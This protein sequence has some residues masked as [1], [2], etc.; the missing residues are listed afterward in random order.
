MIEFDEAAARTIEA[1]YQTPDVVEQRRAVSAALDLRPGERVLD[2]GCGPGLL[3]Q[4]MAEAVE[5]GG[6][7]HGIDPSPSMVEM[8]RRR[9]AAV[10]GARVEV[11]PGE[12][13]E[14]PFPD[15]HFDAVVA[16]QVYEY[17]AAMP[18][19]LTEARRVLVPGGRLLVL[20]TDWDSI[21]WRSSDDARMARVLV[22]WDEHL[23][24][25]DLPRY[26]PRLLADA[27]LRLETCAAVPILNIGEETPTYSSGLLEIVAEFVPGRAGVSAA[28]AAAWAADLRALGP[29]YFFSLNRYVFVARR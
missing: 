13:T 18:R 3:A 2:V 17:V 14:L 20:D 28:Q 10:A 25:R 16:T 6:L 5:P 24:H 19:A 27:G 26:L 4:A 29:D 11:G 12:A 21:V 8:T 1:V 7:V 23:A 22:A 15:E 9:T